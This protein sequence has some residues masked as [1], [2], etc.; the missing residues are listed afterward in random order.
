M[1]SAPLRQRSEAARAAVHY[2]SLPCRKP[3]SRRI[4]TGQLRS[5]VNTNGGVMRSLTRRVLLRGLVIGTALAG[6]GLSAPQANAQEATGPNS[7]NA[8][9]EGIE[10]IVVTAQ[11]RSE[12]VQEV[13]ISPQA[14]PGEALTGQDD[15]KH[16]GRGRVVSIR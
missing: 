1:V 14:L 8:P 7:P 16:V 15:R 6:S 4:D 13:Q 10:D 9:G 2:G 5:S 12:S 3:L 11:R